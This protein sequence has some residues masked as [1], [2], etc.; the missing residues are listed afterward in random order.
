V[1]RDYTI[2]SAK[3]TQSG[4]QLP[5]VPFR[6][7]TETDKKPSFFEAVFEQNGTQYRYGFEASTDRI[8]TEWLFSKKDS[9]RETRLFTREG[10]QFE[11]GQDYREGKGLEGRTRENA[12]F[13]SVAAQFNG[14][15]AGEVIGWMHSFRSIS[16]VD[17]MHYMPFTAERLKE[18]V[19]HRQICELVRMADTGIEDLHTVEMSQESLGQYLPP[20]LFGK[21]LS[22]W[23]G[24]WIKT[25][26]RKFNLEKTLADEVEF[27]LRADES[28]GTQKLVAMAGPV[29]HTLQAG[30]VLF[31]DEMEAR[32]HPLITKS[33]VNLFNS[34]ANKKNAQLI[35]A[36]HDS[37][38]LD[39]RKIRRD[40][41]WF[42]E[43]DQYGASSLYKLSEF[44]IRKEAKFAKEYLLGQFGAVPRVGDWTEVLK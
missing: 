25:K 19:Y 21:E 9:I 43:K 34:S 35:F 12:L 2:N 23:G 1:F 3:E 30:S 17:D 18:S 39:S 27:D 13:L 20:E 31:V 22:D 32:L 6:L 10:N 42:V 14:E 38:L 28:A 7:S 36:T 4:E 41:V 8:V 33:L 16:G 11:I 5:M 26:H 24:F 40:Q 15:V 44:K 29:L 37:G